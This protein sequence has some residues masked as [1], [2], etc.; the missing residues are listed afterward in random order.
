MKALSKKPVAERP[1][2]VYI[3]HGNT[4]R[5]VLKYLRPRRS[6]SQCACSRSRISTA[7]GW[8]RCRRTWNRRCLRTHAPHSLLRHGPGGA[9]GTHCTWP[10]DRETTMTVSDRKFK[11]ILTYDLQADVQ[12]NYFEF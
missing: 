12:D 11:L 8:A 6:G 9:A 7:A 10:V 1:K 4:A 3:A 2:C 5:A